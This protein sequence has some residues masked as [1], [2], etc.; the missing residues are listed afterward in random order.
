MILLPPRS[1]RTD[2]LFPYTTLFR[3]LGPV[4]HR[5]HEGVGQKDAMMQVQR[6]AIE[7]AR[8]FANLQKLLDL[9]VGDIE[10][11]GRR[12]A[13]QRALADRQRKRIHQ[14]R[15]SKRLNSSH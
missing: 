14:D 4:A 5:L 15:K 10:I 13:T 2:T 7:V 12:A 3:S 9:R 1:T 11:T 8:R 6:L